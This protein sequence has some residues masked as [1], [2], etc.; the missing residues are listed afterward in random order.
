MDDNATVRLKIPLRPNNVMWEHLSVGQKERYTWNIDL[1]A[2]I[3]SLMAM[4]TVHDESLVDN[5]SF[6]MH[7]IEILLGQ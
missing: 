2:L 7:T 5:W 1:L 3:C 6:K 4:I